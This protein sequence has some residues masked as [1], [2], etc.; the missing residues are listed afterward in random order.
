[1]FKVG[2]LYSLDVSCLN[3]GYIFEL[4]YVVALSIKIH[5]LSKL[6]LVFLYVLSG[7]FIINDWTFKSRPEVLQ[8][9]Q[10]SPFTE[11]A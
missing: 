9:K 11:N 8:C 3:L 2:N 6:H 10:F 5:F 1:M 4:N 7:K